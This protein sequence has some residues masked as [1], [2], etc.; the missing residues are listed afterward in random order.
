MTTNKL[1]RLEN[2]YLFTNIKGIMIFVLVIYHCI[3]AMLANLRYSHL[4]GQPLIVSVG[5]SALV[6]MFV[7][8]VPIFVTVAGYNSKN[9]DLCRKT[10]FDLYFV[11]YVILMLLMIAFNAVFSGTVTVYIFE[12]LMQLWFL[13]AMFIWMLI[14]KDVVSLKFAIPITVALSIISGM[15]ANYEHFRFTMRLGGFF[16]LSQVFSFL[17][18]LVIGY[19][20]SQ[21]TMSKIC[22]AKPR[23][24][25]IAILLAVAVSVGLGA[26]ICY[27]DSYSAYTLISLK[28][29]GSYLEYF[30]N[31]STYTAVNISGALYRI[32]LFIFVFAVAF[33]LVRFVPRKKVPFLTRIGNAS[34]TIFCLHFFIVMPILQMFKMSMGW[35]FAVTVPLSVIICWVLSIDKVNRTY[36]SIMFKLAD[37]IKVKPKKAES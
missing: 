37:A 4:D 26:V 13:I 5:I 34:L 35:L 29:D 21:N 23:W 31:L 10:A 6:L 36:M 16:A 30:S 27:N 3:S 14:L 7:S 22:N 8:A 28:G 2:H 15:V 20:I 32:A 1:S 25:F 17:P 33:L 24:T 19:K 12:P 9:A 18:F 11:P